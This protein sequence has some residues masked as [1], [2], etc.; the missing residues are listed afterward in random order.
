MITASRDRLAAA[1]VE[2]AD[3]LVDRFDLKVYLRMLADRVTGLTAAAASGVLVANPRGEF[4]F[5]AGSDDVTV[6]DLMRLQQHEGPCRDAFR[7]GRPA[8]NVSMEQAATR[9]PRFTAQAAAAGFRTMHAFPLRQ[10]DQV[11]GALTIFNT[12]KNERLSD[13]D[14]AV[15]QALAELATGAL[16]RRDA[17]RR[18]EKMA[19]HWQQALDSRIVIEQ[20]KGMIAQAH[21][22]SIDEA[23][24]IIRDRARR[25][26]RR[27]TD[28]AHCI[29]TATEPDPE[30]ETLP[31][32]PTAPTPDWVV[33]DGVLSDAPRLAA[34]QRVESALPGAA[35][36]ADAAAHL[37]ARAVGAAMGVV[38]LVRAQGIRCAGLSGA[39]HELMVSR[40][41]PLTGSLCPLVA[42]ADRP[43]IIDD[44]AAHA[45]YA[46]FDAVVR[47]RVRAYLGVPL[48]DRRGRPLGA[49]AAIDTHARRWTDDDLS[50]LLHLAEMLGPLP[51]GD[52]LTDHHVSAATVLDA[53]GEPLISLD[54]DGRVSE[55][56][57]AAAQMFGWP[58]D[59]AI[60]RPVQ[61]LMLSAGQWARIHADAGDTGA[62]PVGL[63]WRQL[64]TARHRAG[65]TFPVEVLVTAL[66]T[67]SGRR[68]AMVVLDG[69]DRA[70][71][72]RLSAR[73]SGFLH[74][75]LDSLHTAV[76]ACDADGRIV[77]F[78]RALRQVHG[79]PDDGAPVDVAALEP[80]LFRP[81]GAPLPLLQTPLMRALHG[82]S[83]RDTE[84]IVKSGDRPALTFTANAGPIRDPDGTLAGAV[85]A[86][87]DIT[88]QRR[89]D[90]F[91][92]CELQVAT[93]LNSTDD[94]ARAGP[95]IAQAVAQTLQWP[96]AE[97]WLHDPVAGTLRAA[98]WWLSPDVAHGVGDLLR[99]EAVNG[100]GITGTVWATGQPLWVP[101]IADTANAPPGMPPALTDAC[102]QAGLHTAVAVPLY[103]GTLIG[104]LTCIADHR[105]YDQADIISGLSA[106]AGHIGRFVSRQHTDGL[107][108]QLDRT[109]DDFIALVGHEMRTPLTSIAAG[110][111]L[112]L[113]EDDLDPDVRQLLAVADRNTTALTGIVDALLDLAALDS[114]HTTMHPRP[115]DITALVR[116][117]LDAIAPAAH[118]NHVTLDADLPD[119]AIIDA[120]P[121]RLRQ[122]IDNL[123]SNAVKYSPDGGTTTIT[124]HSDADTTVLSV[125]D[126]GIG[127]P[128][129]D[130]TALFR[131]F[132]RASNARHTAIPGNGLG[133]VTT[134]AII[135]AH[136]GHV[137]ATHNNPGTTITIRLPTTAVGS[138]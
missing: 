33:D 34:V 60:G 27:L 41:L 79:L 13:A 26:R 7:T 66:P 59:E 102:A 122:V 119:Q 51:E 104:V 22:V 48:H 110:I 12:T 75:V 52:L 23:F 82:S 67:A 9:W 135:E 18:S 85:V 95:Q 131:T 90:R 74:A 2:I 114:G 64:I 109:R 124:L 99:T 63:P 65:H 11:I 133:L 84:V 25:H 37:A 120:D 55:W 89:A 16:L 123:L 78:N 50:A 1:F 39:P 137:T 129:Q 3:T 116:A 107:T 35:G 130:R 126:T 46:A 40:E 20:A 108:T 96:Y 19:G 44:T 112:L 47:Y 73:R 103:N 6:A 76:A 113:T 49:V 106:V 127:I 61:Q 118:A 10:R 121:Q 80:P 21:E 62:G 128:P 132:F 28:V 72:D 87:H 100:H 58:A 70:D 38:S 4:G 57:S 94:V 105:E 77:L 42:S 83:V 86:L 111:Q 97:L 24:T 98:G 134:R 17:V 101:D 92:T 81:D 5:A 36:S 125:S 91:R 56:N 14:R 136:H 15:I 138:N 31:R 117:S 93:A 88:A 115:T 45:E 8:V 32:P 29:V 53:L 30:S 54:D 68:W 43:L 69:A 71:A